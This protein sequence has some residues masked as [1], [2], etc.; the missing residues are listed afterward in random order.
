MKAQAFLKSSIVAGLSV[1]GSCA[2]ADAAT[3]IACFTSDTKTPIH[4]EMRTYYDQDIQFSFGSI[5]YA[6]AKTAIPIVLKSDV[7]EVQGGRAA[8]EVTTTWLEVSGGSVSGSYKSVH[9]G[10]N[11]GSMI[12]TNFR[13]KKT[14][15]FMLDTHIGS[16][17]EKG[18]AWER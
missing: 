7:A 17:L 14:V 10:A 9:Q 2:F 4:F 5:K 3:D 12:Y 18:C 16:T 13:T 6:K 15:E 8:D 11:V 1:A